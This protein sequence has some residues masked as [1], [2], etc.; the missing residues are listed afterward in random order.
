STPLLSSLIARINYPYIILY[1]HRKSH[2]TRTVAVDM[3][4]VE[5]E[6]HQTFAIFESS[7]N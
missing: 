1:S 7:S 2:R 5:I 6:T 4:L 3:G